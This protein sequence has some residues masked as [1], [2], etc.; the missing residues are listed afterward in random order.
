M[1][2]AAPQKID[3]LPKGSMNV[4]QLIDTSP[5][6]K[7]QFLIGILCFL[8]IFLDGL[9][10][11]AMGFIAPSLIQEWGV[12][13]AHLG[14]VMSAALGGMIVGALI[15]GPM[16]DRFGRKI[17]IV[18][19]MLTFGVFSLVSALANTL[20]QLVVLRFLT[21]I[22]L[23]AAMPNVTTI[24]SEYVPKRIRSFVVTTMFCG[25]NLGM[26]MAGFI[27]SGL[28]PHFGWR[29]FF[30]LGGCLPIL[31]VVFVI[32]LLPES[33]RYLLIQGTQAQ[34]IKRILS[35]IAPGQVDKVN[36]THSSTAAQTKVSSKLAHIFSASYRWGTFLLWATYFMGLLV[37][38]LM[39]SWLPTMLN[40]TGASIQEAT[41]IGGL[42]QFG[43]ILGAIFIG[44]VM[45]RYNPNRIIAFFYLVAGLLTFVLGQS[46]NN[47]TMFALLVPLAGLCING[48]QSAMPSLSARFYPT[49]SRATGVAW[50]L[51]VGRFGAVIGAWLGGTFIKLEWTFEEILSFLL[52]PAIAAS[53]FILIKSYVTHSDVTE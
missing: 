33:I 12:N 51:G 31:L 2:K 3:H 17:V 19:S 37:I 48:A 38:Y 47:L 21:G 39:T 44:W 18:I 14:F 52:I 53:I 10:T 26:A 34:K 36:L 27:S 8:S 9:D 16:A 45:D 35:L 13:K 40:A 23:G 28:I 42:Y 24:L 46:L 20:E 41:F 6:S 15:S 49:Q 1:K 43:G 11:A 32:F 25:F 22:G 50:M 29:A 30:L 5:L 4:Q 7:Y